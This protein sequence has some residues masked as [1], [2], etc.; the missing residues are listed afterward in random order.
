MRDSVKNLTEV[1]V[2]YVHCFPLFLQGSYLIT[3]GYQ[4]G[5]TSFPFDKFMLNTPNQLLLLYSYG[6]VFQEDFLHHLPR[7][8]GEAD[9]PV[10]PWIFFLDLLEYNIGIC[11]L[12]VFRNLSQSP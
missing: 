7:N 9:W 1:E 6:N 5:Q 3:E 8:T 4:V 10:V 2:N 12:P 11:S